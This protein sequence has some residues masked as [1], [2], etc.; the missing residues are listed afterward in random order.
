MN[1]EIAESSQ[2]RILIAPFGVAGTGV[3]LQV[4]L[5]QILTSPLPNL[6]IT[7]IE[8]DIYIII[9]KS[10]LKGSNKKYILRG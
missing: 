9:F 10:L 2:N 3:N 7:Y 8:K 1:C 5:C 4:A 6:K